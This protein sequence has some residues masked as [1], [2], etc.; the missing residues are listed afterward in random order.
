MMA[1][2]CELYS[3]ILLSIE[4]VRST[5]KSE[6]LVIEQ[7]V[8]SL[9]GIY[10]NITSAR[11]L[12]ACVMLQLVNNENALNTAGDD[13]LIATYDHLT[14]FLAMLTMG[15]CAMEKLYDTIEVGSVCLKRPIRQEG[16]RI[17]TGSLVIW[18]SFEYPRL[19]R[20]VDPRYTFIS[21]KS[22]EERSS[23]TAGSIM[24]F[25]KRITHQAYSIYDCQ[26][27]D[28]YLNLLYT[29]HGFHKGGN[30]PQISGQ[31]PFICC[32]TGNYIGQDPVKYTINANYAGIATI[33]RRALT[34]FV[35]HMMDLP[36]FSCNST[37]CLS[38]LVKLG[39]FDQRKEIELIVGEEGRTKLIDEFST[40]ERPLVTYSRLQ[41]I[42]PRFRLAD[43][44]W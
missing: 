10:G 35:R 24:G 30:V 33:P 43:E 13:G 31:Q 6:Y 23:A 17:Y 8:A 4:R 7:E 27:I 19:K 5:Y 26:L 40:T 37:G 21:D 14:P 16:L 3:G 12:H 36:T 42:P 2:Y 32:I 34:P 38:Y 29:R 28:K 20:E 18:P 25:L 22:K 9:L 15:S 11:F 39:Y 41:D 44:Y 1:D